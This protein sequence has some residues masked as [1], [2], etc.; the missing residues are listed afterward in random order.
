MLSFSSLK[1]SVSIA[2]LVRLELAQLPSSVE[3][4]ISSLIC[5][6]TE[7]MGTAIDLCTHRIDGYG[8]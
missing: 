2:G 3:F 8:Y 1:L 7:S 4:N 5:V 6:L